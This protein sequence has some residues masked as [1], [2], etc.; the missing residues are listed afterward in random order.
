MKRIFITTPSSKAG[1][2]LLSL[3]LSKHSQIRQSAIHE[4]HLLG[5]M[6]NLP[7]STLNYEQ[8]RVNNGFDPSY[9][10]DK[11]IKH[12]KQLYDRMVNPFN[13]YTS[14]VKFTE[15]KSYRW[16]R[17][18]FNDAYIIV[19][20]REPLDWYL[21]WKEWPKK[22]HLNVPR[23]I[24]RWFDGLIK[25][26]AHSLQDSDRIHIVHF[27]DLVND[28]HKT[29]A[30]VHNYLGLELESVNLDNHQQIYLEK[31]SFTPNM[32]MSNDSLV[33]DTI[34]RGK[35][36]LDEKE[37]NSLIHLIDSDQIVKDLWIK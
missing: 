19:L 13:C 27:E 32:L 15:F 24:D 4:E 14:A 12:V 37:I 8:K 29:M 10:T 25:P 17:S 6:L 5:S 22:N 3:L 35:H 20:L 36:M 21:S 11:N 33:L 9:L 2:T 31:T 7:E 18:L 26:A 1:S 34:G 28:P 23:T 16:L 30:A